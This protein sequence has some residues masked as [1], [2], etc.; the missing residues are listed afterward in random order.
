MKYRRARPPLA[1]YG[2]RWLPLAVVLAAA[3]AR[4][5]EPAFYALSARRGAALSTRPLL[6]ELRRPSLPPYLDRP[7]IVRRA[8]A[9]RLALDGT[10][11]WGAP[12]PE[13]VVQTLGEDLSARLPHCFVV[14]ETTGMAVEADVRVDLAFS[15]FEVEGDGAAAL[16]ATV[17]VRSTRAA[18]QP[19]LRR[20]DFKVASAP[21]ASSV[22]AAMSDALAR[23]ADEIA[24]SVAGVSLPAESEGGRAVAR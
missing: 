3:C 10:A 7:Y 19:V 2:S 1:R 22:A 21:S 8:T 11:H 24:R 9:E 18:R 12:L 20:Y 5:P 23:L 16:S 17:A 4:S 14:S 13:L 6:I 15:R